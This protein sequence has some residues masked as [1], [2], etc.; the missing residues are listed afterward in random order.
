[1]Q[2]KIGKKMDGNMIEMCKPRPPPSP[3]SE[4]PPL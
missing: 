2:K 4:L 3:L 1:M